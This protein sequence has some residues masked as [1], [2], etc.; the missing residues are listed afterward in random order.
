MRIAATAAPR[1]GSRMTMLGIVLAAGFVA[2]AMNAAAGGGSF[3]SIPALMAAGLPALAANISSTIAL[4]PGSIASAWAYRHDFKP[5]GA[6]SLPVLLALSLAGGCAGAALLLLTPARAFDVAVPWLLLVATLT[7][8]F[9]RGLG[10]RLRRA[11]RIGP[12]TLMVVQFVLAIYGGYFGG[13]VGIMMMAAWTLL[14]T[15]DIAAMNPV[16][17]ILVSAMNAVAVV[18]FVAASGVW[19]PQT[20]AML[21]GATAGGYAGARAARL[22]PPRALRLGVVTLTALITAAFFWRAYGA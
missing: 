1:D 5:F 11:V 21:V 22:L 14:S 17:T 12:A 10:E 15:A 6:V 8:A 18:C 16:R 4:L 2:G 20:L 7:L 9:G 3:V 19:W 13:A